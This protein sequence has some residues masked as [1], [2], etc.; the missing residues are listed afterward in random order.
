MLKTKVILEKEL[1][2]VIIRFHQEIYGKGPED[3]WV[4]IKHNIAAFHC[5]KSITAME[6]FL[7]NIPGGDE[8]VV[9]LRKK[10]MTF[11]KPRL[12]SEIEIISG[13]KVLGM[14]E[15]ICL[16]SKSFFGAI[17]FAEHFEPM[18]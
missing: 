2:R 12:C 17:L 16:K 6:E 11:I 14:T 15:E 10:I 9:Q 18:Q 8:E 13:I 3:I 1:K 4:N 5:S 7:L